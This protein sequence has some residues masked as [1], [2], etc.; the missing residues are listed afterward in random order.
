[1][2]LTTK[3]KKKTVAFY[4]HL[5]VQTVTPKNNFKT[6]GNITQNEK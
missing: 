3:I 2:K 1:M 6:L 5:N 4:N